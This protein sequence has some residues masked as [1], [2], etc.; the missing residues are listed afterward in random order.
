MA[1][2]VT[3]AGKGSPLTN[4]EVDANFTNLNTQFGSYLP[5]AG[6]TLTGLL[7]IT[8]AS[9][10][11][12]FEL[13]RN[14]T[15]NIGGKFANTNHTTYFGLGLANGE[16]RVGASSD[17]Q[18]AGNIVLHSANFNTY[19]QPIDADLTAIGAIAATAGL[20]RKTA[21]NTW[22]LDTSTYLTGN[23]SISITGDASG[24]GTTSISLTL[25]ASGVTAGTYTKLT[26]DAKG[27]AT[28]GSSL[29]SS[30]VTTALGYTPYNSTNP[31][32]YIT[33]IN[34]SMVTTALGYTPYNSSNPNGYITSSGS[35]SGNAATATNSTQLGGLTKSNLWNNSGNSHSTYQTFG[36]I[37]DFGVWFMQGSTAADSPQSGSQYFLQ[38]QGLGS[39]YGYSSYALMT[40]VA[41][42][43]A[44]KYTYYRTREGGTWGSWTKGAA[45]YADSAGSVAWTNVSG[46]P[47]TVSSFTNDSG[48]ITSSGSITGNAAT[49]TSVTGVAGVLGYTTSAQNTAAGTGIGPQI[50]S[51]GGGGAVLSFHRPGA[52]GLNMGLDSDNVFRIGGWSASANRL[53]MDM[54]G[55]LTMNGNVTAYSDE[56]LKRNWT[57]LPS[58][59]VDQ[60][61][62]VKHGIYDRIGEELRQVG[63]SAQSLQRLLREAVMVGNDEQKTLSVAYGNAALTSA[64]Q[65]AIR[66]VAQEKRIAALEALVIG[67]N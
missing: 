34:S 6:G 64:I 52:Y 22:S 24:S 17:L 25:S 50:T 41:R 5:L 35:I 62:L 56:R 27:R 54:N 9:V 67:D 51:Q 2:I 14:S 47:T 59:F 26:V 36:A 8:T 1:T 44:V 4:A 46:R 21:A 48:Y 16:L 49:A 45:G 28:G 53:Q 65:L 10:A 42:D 15:Q 20:L 43:H 39:D 66:V 37:P 31:S 29:A 58:D 3:R 32:G 13:V 19:A 30:D 55:N 23:Q 11:I 7:S 33:G 63:V 61:A 60:L 40:A 18:G 12:P 57:D 38:T